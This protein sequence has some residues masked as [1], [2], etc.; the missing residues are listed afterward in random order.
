[1]VDDFRSEF[2]LEA[3]LSKKRF[4][5]QDNGHGDSWGHIFSQAGNE[6]GTSF[7]ML[8]SYISC[9]AVNELVHKLTKNTSSE[10]STEILSSKFDKSLWIKG[11]LIFK[12]T[13][14]LI[15]T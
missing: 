4:H 15:L 10:Q 11:Y 1:M 3:S 2:V 12:D 13:F 8:F 9:L 14:N 7:S 5:G 6:L